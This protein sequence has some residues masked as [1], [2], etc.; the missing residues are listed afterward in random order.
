MLVAHRPVSR[1]FPLAEPAQSPS[2]L[3]GYLWTREGRLLSPL[4]WSHN[5]FGICTRVGG[6]QR[7]STVI[8]TY[9]AHRPDSEAAALVI[10]LIAYCS[11]GA[12]LAF[13]LYIP[14]CS[15]RALSTPD[16]PRTRLPPERWSSIVIRTA[17]KRRG[18]GCACY[19][20]RDRTNNDRSL[21]A[22]AG[23]KTDGHGAFP[24]ECRRQVPPQR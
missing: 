24:T 1:A 17:K 19:P 16:W 11:V 6:A 8:A 4:N 7:A 10:H 3:L 13:G 20:D 21:D 22:R 14:S 9:S 2:L 12:C 15:P 5:N 18:A 23:N